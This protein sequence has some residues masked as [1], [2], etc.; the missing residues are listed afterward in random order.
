M[1]QLI[2]EPNSDIARQCLL[3]LLKQVPY[4]ACMLNLHKILHVKLLSV[5]ASTRI[6]FK[7]SAKNPGPV[8]GCGF[9]LQPAPVEVQT[10]A[11]PRHLHPSPVLHGGTNPAM[12]LQRV[13]CSTGIEAHRLRQRQAKASK[14]FKSSTVT[15]AHLQAQPHSQHASDTH[16]F[17]GSLH[18]L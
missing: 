6:L 2:V 7:K 16:C 18:V 9:G 4:V 3:N 17:A 13:S 14:S 10:P 8:P 15:T 1:R 12:L 11:K 5:R